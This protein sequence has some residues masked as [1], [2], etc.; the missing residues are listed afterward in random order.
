MIMTYFTTKEPLK[1]N[2]LHEVMMIEFVP[3]TNCKDINVYF[4]NED[5]PLELKGVAYYTTE[6]E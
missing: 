6:D 4:W 2:V 1:P 3:G 5:E